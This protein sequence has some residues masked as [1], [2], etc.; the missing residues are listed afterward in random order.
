MVN[1]TIQYFNDSLRVLKR[2]DASTI[3]WD[4]T[5]W[6]LNDVQLRE[7]DLEKQ[8]NFSYQKRAKLTLPD[9]TFIPSDLEE[10]KFL[11]GRIERYLT[12]EELENYSA[13]LTSFAQPTFIVDYEIYNALLFPFAIFFMTFIGALLGS[14]SNRGGT[15]VYFFICL[16]I[17]LVYISIIV[18]GKIFGQANTISPMLGA[19]LPHLV[20][21]FVLFALAF[22]R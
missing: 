17:C 19:L 15:M 10:K 18:L 3:V 21:S 9:L 8:V 11:A 20:T 5:K 2:V 4:S 14:I 6:V 22:R 16:L 7:R 13:K 1:A 12:L